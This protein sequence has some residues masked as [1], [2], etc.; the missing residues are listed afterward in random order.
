M[1]KMAWRWSTLGAALWV[2]TGC[3]VGPEF[4]RPSAPEESRYTRSDPL[5]IESETGAQAQRIN[6]GMNVPLRWWRAFGSTELDQLLESA[7]AASPSMEAARA[8]VAQAEQVLIAAH[9]PYYPQVSVQA[10]ATRAVSTGAR[11]QSGPVNQISVLPVVS[12]TPDLSGATARRVEQAQALLDVQRAQWAAA[13]L[14][15][16]GNTVL[17]AIALADASA[18]IAAMNDIISLDRHNLDLV[19]LSAAAGKVARLDVLTAESQLASDRA[20]LP[21]LQQ[22]ASIA[23]HALAVL[24]GR[25]SANWTPPAFE[26]TMLALPQELPLALPS[27]LAR[28]RPDIRVAESQLHATSAAIG[29]ATA[30]LYPTLTLNTSWG[31]VAGTLGGLFAPG[32]NVWSVAADLLAPAFSGYALQAQRDAALEAYAAQLA[33][34]RQTVLQA[35]AQ[36]ADVLDALQNDAAQLQAQRTALDAAQSV[37]D[38]TQQSYRAGH[39]SLLQLLVA[40]RLFQQARLGYA[41]AQAQRLADSAQLFIVM[42]GA[43]PLLS[44]ARGQS[45]L[46]YD[47]R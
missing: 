46:I 41:K 1:S 35:F 13:W 40:Q 21:P 43:T 34:Y 25:T 19:Q 7:L 37:V 12:F 2:L 30:Q 38:L 44:F 17:Q 29:I 20:L 45:R 9:G 28:S 11:T 32:T 16:T 5:R 18:Q 23:R 42:G 4:V 31:S 14:A 10:A 33:V 3:M 47:G 6:S 27:Q 15:L 22:Q 24:A 26:L 36:V 39:A 8:T